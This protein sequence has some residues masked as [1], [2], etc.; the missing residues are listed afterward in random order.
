MT[1]SI[2][3]NFWFYPCGK[4]SSSL[5]KKK[6]AV[7]VHHSH[8]NIFVSLGQF[9]E[10]IHDDPLIFDGI[11][12]IRTTLEGGDSWN[13]ELQYLELERNTHHLPL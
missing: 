8:P 9:T 12:I 4:C 1:H 3:R 2:V 7:A 11:A 13:D 6:L 5:N 10:K